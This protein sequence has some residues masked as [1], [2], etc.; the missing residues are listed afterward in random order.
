MSV[1]NR[2]L[3][4][5]EE[6][7]GGVP[8]SA[9]VRAVGPVARRGVSPA[10]L[11]GV[12]AG[13]FLAGG[14]LAAWL[15]GWFDRTAPAPVVASAPVTAP[16]APRDTAPMPP[17]AQP[18]QAPPPSQARTAAVPTKPEAGVT[19]GTPRPGAAVPRAPADATPAAAGAGDTMPARAA[20]PKQVATT[21]PARE[22]TAKPATA[23]TGAETASRPVAAPADARA[24][25]RTAPREPAP[26]PA[27]AP[28]EVSAEPSSMPAIEKRERPL[29]AAERG[30]AAYRQGVAQIQSGRS[31]EAEATFRQALAEDPRH[32]GAR[33]ALL[34]MML[35]GRRSAEAEALMREGIAA[36]PTQ[37][38][39]SMVLARLQAERGDTAGGIETL[40]AALAQG[41]RQGGEFHALLAALLQRAGDHKGAVQSYQ[42]ALAT[43]GARPAWHMGQA[44]SLRELG[45]KDEARAAFQKAI[46]GGL[47]GELR[48]FV[49]RQ[50]AAL[51]R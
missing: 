20:T 36:D 16:A 28:A 46:D 38:S 24:A 11:G 9:A 12:A 47:P 50:L 4:D 25:K 21:D 15:A 44:I 23:G 39:W 31:A 19:P 2:V 3:Q 51:G 13:V 48:A 30:E 18:Q 8:P 10:V 7:R 17:E 35:D 42:D 6:R 45:R 43:P 1:I 32:P 22:A 37:S 14:A 40:R 27:P 33:Q 49:E 26:A 5:L 34:G 29:S 41:A